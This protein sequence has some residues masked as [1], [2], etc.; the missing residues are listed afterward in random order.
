MRSVSA[1]AIDW[2]QP[3]NQEWEF[4][5][6]PAKQPFYRK[7]WRN[8]GGASLLLSLADGWCRTRARVTSAA[9]RLLS[10]IILL[11]YHR[12]AKAKRATA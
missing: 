11:W 9:Y 10:P 3:E 8:L 7:E 12:Q 4:F 1:L 6:H 2:F 5:Q